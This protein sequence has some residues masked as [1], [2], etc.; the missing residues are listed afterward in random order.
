M[1]RFKAMQVFTRVVEAGSFT[2][3]AETLEMPRAT[4]TTSVQQLE[5]HLGVRL[6][7]RTTRRVAVTVDG[8]A[9]YERCLHLLEALA[10]TEAMLTEGQRPAGRLRVNLPGRPARLLIIPALRTFCDRY[11]ELDLEIGVSDRPVDLIQ[12]GM[13]CALRVGPLPDSGLVARRVGELREI[14]CAAPSYLERF[15]TP[16]VPADLA[17]HQAVHYH[18]ARTGRSLPWEYI[19]DGVLREITL[20]ARIT[21]DN[22]E[23]YM[24]A[25]LAGLGLIQAPLHGLADHLRNGELV[26]VL[27]DY[28][29]APS[30]MSVVYPHNRHLSGK[31]KVFVDW[32][33][34]LLRG[35]PGVT[36]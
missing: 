23:A 10:D 11:P 31:V 14:S 2:R 13:D 15:G 5:A 33:I 29:P 17:G 26:E 36:S 32:L 25:A 12:E 27:P 22:T 1:D 6:L 7:N 16:S 30:L 35:H 18:A 34:T 28:R 4:V 3:A 24:A 20:P 8:G 21:T 9:Y 19:E